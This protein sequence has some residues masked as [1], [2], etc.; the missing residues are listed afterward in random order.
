VAWARESNVVIA[1]ESCLSLIEET[2]GEHH[3]YFNIERDRYFKITHGADAANAG[4]AL[5]VDTDFRIGK[6]TQCYIAVPWLREATPF[7]YLARL[8]LFNLTFRDDVEIEGVIVEYGKEAIVVSQ[9][10]IGGSA[11][12]AADVAAFM[13]Q[14]GFVALPG[15]T[16]GRGNSA[17]Y[18]HPGEAIAVFDTHGQNFLV[19]GEGIIPIDA[20]ILRAS[21]DLLAYLAM[22]PAER[23]EETG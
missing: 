22:S 11:A 1:A 21:E 7:E 3:V 23:A 13:L 19:S 6:K 2:H 9:R 4:F 15:V 14:R 17:S 20:L 5:T 12:T 8:Q 10:F 16:V 18:L